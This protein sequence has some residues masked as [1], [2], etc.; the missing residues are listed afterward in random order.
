MAFA[1]DAYAGQNRIP[2]QAG[3]DKGVAARP[4]L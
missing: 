2:P 1:A 3:C 4:F